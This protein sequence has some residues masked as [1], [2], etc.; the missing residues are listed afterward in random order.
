MAPDRPCKVTSAWS[1]LSQAEGLAPYHLS[2]YGLGKAF[3]KD[4]ARR[5]SSSP[6]A[7]A[8]GLFPGDKD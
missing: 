7:N 5:C 4:D 3:Q 1:G 6:L 2:F 8:N